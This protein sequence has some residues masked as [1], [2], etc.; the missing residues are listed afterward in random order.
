MTKIIFAAFT[1]LAASAG[2]A[3]AE[4]PRVAC[5]ADAEKLC[6]QAIGN[7]DQVAACLKSNKDKLSDACK[8]AIANR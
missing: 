5:R 3:M 6:A 2:V 8:Q 1:L 4:D 7:R